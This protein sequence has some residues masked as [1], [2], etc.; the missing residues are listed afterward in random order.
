MPKVISGIIVWQFGCS[1]RLLVC[2]WF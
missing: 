1:T 2:S